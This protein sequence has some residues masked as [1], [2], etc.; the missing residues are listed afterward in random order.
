[1]TRQIVEEAIEAYRQFGP[2]QPSG[3]WEWIFENKKQ[4]FVEALQE[5][6]ADRVEELLSSF[7][8]NEASYG[9]VSYSA[10]QDKGEAYSAILRDAAVFRDLCGSDF[11]VLGIP[12]V[13]APWGVEIEGTLVLPDASRHYYH[14]DRLRALGAEGAVMEIGGGYGGV[15][16]YLWTGGARPQSY[17]NCDLVE[18]LVVFYLLREQGVRRNRD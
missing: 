10:L 14:A 17:V 1:M 15:F 12:E 5:G 16:W 11:S 7:F 2:S 3:N 18:A 4:G 8:R 9:I 13:G 6:D